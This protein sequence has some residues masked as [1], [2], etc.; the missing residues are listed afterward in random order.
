MNEFFSIIRG[1]FFHHLLT[2]GQI[3]LATGNDRHDTPAFL[4]LVNIGLFGHDAPPQQPVVCSA[5]ASM[6]HKGSGGERHLCWMGDEA[7]EH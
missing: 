4:A 7:D 1:N 6:V 5:R 3:P 2:A